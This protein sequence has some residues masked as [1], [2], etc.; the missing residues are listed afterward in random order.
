MYVGDFVLFDLK[1]ESGIESDDNDDSPGL[2]KLPECMLFI[3]KGREDLLFVHGYACSFTC[4]ASYNTRASFSQRLRRR[5]SEAGKRVLR[6]LLMMCLL[7][8]FSLCHPLLLCLTVYFPGI[9]VLLLFLASC[10]ERK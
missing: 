1:L 2:Q 9:Q 10:N 6:C 4:E 8:T 5:E 3:C 7:P